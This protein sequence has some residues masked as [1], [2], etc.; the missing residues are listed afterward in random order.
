M[1]NKICDI[2]LPLDAREAPNKT[3]WPVAMQQLQ[4]LVKVIEGCGWKANVLN[5]EKPVSSVA[6]GV[7][8]V[9]QAK[10][11]RFINFMAGSF[12]STAN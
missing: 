7:A 9:K 11:D 5:P 1:T 10:G 12:N 4:H 6:E 2:Y 3:V 8:V